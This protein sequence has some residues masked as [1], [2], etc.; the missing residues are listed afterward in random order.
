MAWLIIQLLITLGLII[1]GLSGQLVLRGTDSS[2]AL[3]VFGCLWLIYD[4]YQIAAY[5]KRKAQ[6]AVT[7]SQIAD[8]QAQE[9]LPSPYV[10]E[11]TRKSGVVGAAV[12]YKIFLNGEPVGELR[13]GGTLSVETRFRKNAVTS[14]VFM[15]PF[16]FE[17]DSNGRAELQFV[18]ASKNSNMQNFEI[19]SGAAVFEPSG[20][21][22]YK[23]D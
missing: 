23:F 3:V 18:Q 5:R 12:K 7:N 10:I 19:T 22:A 6:D 20:V 8:L 1:G 15:K 13:N 4:I 2:P 11:M 14:P 17:I 21:S 9:P 16:F